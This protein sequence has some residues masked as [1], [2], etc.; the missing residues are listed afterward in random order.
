MLIVQR[1][2]KMEKGKTKFLVSILKD[3]SLYQTM[4]HEE[5]LIL[6]SKIENDYP[7]IFNSPECKEEE[8]KE[9]L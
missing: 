7:S 3:S 1:V 2:Y 9:A 4:T 6:I 5:K 8:D